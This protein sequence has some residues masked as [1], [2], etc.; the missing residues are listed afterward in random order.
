MRSG[1][2]FKLVTQFEERGHG[3]SLEELQVIYEYIKEKPVS[4]EEAGIA[5]AQ[6]KKQIL[7][8]EGLVRDKNKRKWLIEL[9]YLFH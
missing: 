3:Y 6:F 9:E 4:I 1:E 7:A 8:V 5:K 2:I